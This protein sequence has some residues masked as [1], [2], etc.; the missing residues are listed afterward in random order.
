M[1]QTLMERELLE[2]VIDLLKLF[3][4]RYYHTYDSRRSVHG[5]PDITAVR[6]KRLL[7][8]ELKSEKGKLTQ[9]QRLWLADLKFTERA[10]TYV[11]RPS[12]WA[13]I[14]GCLR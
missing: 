6:G 3:H 2:A 12:D 10:E 13:E 14:L 8:I 9:G 1:K 7:F 11:W 4:W 5:Y